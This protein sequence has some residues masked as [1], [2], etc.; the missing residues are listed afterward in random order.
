MNNE[1]FKDLTRIVK[2]HEEQMEA[3]LAKLAE[4]ADE[5]N[6]SA[7]VVNMHSTALSNHADVLRSLSEPC[8]DPECE[9]CEE[10]EEE[11]EEESDGDY[12]H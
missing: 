8:G 5:H 4:L 7:G 2:R 3:L 1:D 12:K 10:V 11:E 6:K 9:A